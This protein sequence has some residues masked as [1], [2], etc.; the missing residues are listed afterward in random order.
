MITD[1][2]QRYNDR[3]A[4]LVPHDGRKVFDRR[5]YDVEPI[6]SDGA[7]RP[8]V[9]AHHYSASY[10]A[11]RF[12]FG[13]YHRGALVGAAVF[14]QAMN[15]AATTNWLRGPS[16][17][18]VEFGRFVLLGGVPA[19][20]EGWMAAR[21]Y[22]AL[23]REGITGVVTFADDTAR[24]VGDRTLFPGHIGTIYQATNAHFVSERSRGRTLRLLPSGA[25]FS[26]RTLAK[27]RGGERGRVGAARQ[28]VEAGAAAP[29]DAVL[30]DAHALARWAEAWV[31][32][33]TT[34]LR[35]PGNLRYLQP[36]RRGVLTDRAVR[37]EARYPKVRAGSQLALHL[38]AP[39]RLAA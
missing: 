7:V 37:L 30:Y 24:R 23:R 17:E 9:E 25:V 12:R 8:F 22:R 27:L 16:V 19:G 33:V 20:A 35:H 36:L 11:A 1:Y 34:P 5:A 14:S 18:H 15:E 2:V 6:A 26:D 38:P 4:R 3:H 29:S 13:L 28:L 10:P 39:T 31:P 21:C 32:R